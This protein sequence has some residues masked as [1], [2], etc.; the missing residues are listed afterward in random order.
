M[1]DLLAGSAE[2]WRDRALDPPLLPPSL[3]PTP[4]DA[5]LR[6]RVDGLRR[7]HTVRRERA[8]QVYADSR[9]PERGWPVADDRAVLRFAADLV[10]SRRRWFVAMVLL[11]A[12]AAVAALA[13]PKLLG[14]L[15]DRVTGTGRPRASA[16]WP[17]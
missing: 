15:V 16:R 12:A 9:S 11:N 6:A 2:T 5:D 10:R 13:V 7:R 4:P 3:D 8:E 14:V 17:W 1:S